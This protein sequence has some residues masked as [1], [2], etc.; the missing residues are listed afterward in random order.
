M[1]DDALIIVGAGIGGLTLAAALARDG[2]R[3]RVLEQADA[4][5]EVGAGVG[6]WTNAAR[7][8]SAIG[9]PPSLW[10]RGSE[11]RCGEIATA[12][13]RVV[14]RVDVA[15]ITSAFGAGSY[16]VHRAE[17]HAAIASLVDP[18][19]VTLGA[20]VSGLEQDAD[21]VTVRL[22]GGG[23]VRGALVVGADGLRSAVRA[24][25]L[26]EAAPSYAGETC[27]R[28][29]CDLG[30]REPH[31][32]REVQGRGLRCA[33]CSIG[34]GRIYWWATR[35]APEGE[36]DVPEER[37]AALAAWFDGFAFGFPEALEA[38][39]PD[40]ILRNDLYDRP[41][42]PSWSAGRVTLLGDAAH[43]TTPNLGQGACMAIEDAI[44]L[45]RALAAHP[46]DHARA[47]A[48]YER[49]RMPRT[50]RIVEQSRRVGRIGGWSSAP[51]VA[52]RSLAFAATPDFLV[53]RVMRAQL[54][55]DATRAPL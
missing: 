19:T 13:G 7:C 54:G 49:A 39:R 36:P 48:A 55:Y 2:R 1:D 11:V 25:I 50:S 46:T 12:S 16:V 30:A 10:E 15:G 26:G 28:G 40:A 24:A 45:A 8:L 18:A 22:D 31:V 47:F 38:T 52:L 23:A 4:L 5:G 32:L 20:R 9:V 43:P 3:V 37:K 44:V 51:L 34:P 27:Y 35:P 21:G 17:L 53:D 33:V 29:V 42:A 41:P 14:S 6:L